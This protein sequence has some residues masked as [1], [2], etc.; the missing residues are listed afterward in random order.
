MESQRKGLAR[1][2]NLF[3]PAWV[4]VAC[5]LPASSH[6]QGA[7]RGAAIDPVKR[8]EQQWALLIGVNQYER[9]GSLRYCQRDM[10]SLKNRLIRSGFLAQNVRLLTGQEKDSL[11][12]PNK[13]NIDRELGRVVKKVGP[14]DLIVV[15]FSG[16]GACL[17]GT[18]YLC[19]ADAM[20]NKAEDT[21]ITVKSVYE[22]L[23]QCKAGYKLLIVDA[24]RNDPRKPRARSVERDDSLHQ[25]DFAGSMKD[26]PTGILALVSCSAGET[27]LEDDSLQHGVFMHF[28]IDGLAGNARDRDG[29]IRLLGLCNYATSKTEE[30]VGR[31]QRPIVRGD[32]PNCELVPAASM[33][34]A[35]FTLRSRGPNGPPAAN[36][37]VVLCRGDEKTKRWEE[38]ARGTTD[39]RGS[40]ELA[41]IAADLR[42]AG[43]EYRLHAKCK[44]NPSW[45]LPGFPRTP[46]EPLIILG[47][48]REWEET[49]ANVKDGELPIGWSSPGEGL[50]VEHK[51]G[52]ARLVATQEG[53][54]H[55]LLPAADISGDFMLEADVVVPAGGSH[56][57]STAPAFRIDFE[58]PGRPTIQTGVFI[59]RGAFYATLSGAPDAQ[60]KRPFP[61]YMADVA[62]VKVLRENGL[63]KVFVGGELFQSRKIDRPF[64][65]VRLVLEKASELH[66][67]KMCIVGSPDNGGDQRGG[68]ESRPGSLVEFFT[69]VPDGELPAGWQPE[70]PDAYR[71]QRVGGYPQLKMAQDNPQQVMLPV[72]DLPGDFNLECEIAVPTGYAKINAFQVELLSRTQTALAAGACIDGGGF[73]VTMTRNVKVSKSPWTRYMPDTASFRIT[74]ENGTIGVYVKDELFQ[75]IRLT[76]PITGVRLG[77]NKGAT[78]YSIK[79]EPVTS[80]APR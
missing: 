34:K 71:V 18:S 59:A 24:C 4:L 54:P 29:G 43:G 50:R 40:V 33:L 62:K 32:T 68:E 48:Q 49:F 13:K 25:N 26:P 2:T 42:E 23:S 30:Y 80:T 5:L 27:S 69:A 31:S 8:A 22:P 55:A 14:S 57:H 72:V 41:V 38:M 12:Y 65:R 56:S 9:L 74:R 44:G 36:T 58:A 51:E 17:E 64:S 75:S 19:P 53:R 77:L 37:E 39:Q 78:L 70:T 45:R 20:L 6:G 7:S 35:Q 79:V 11:D 3:V 63:F 47:D 76:Q 60:G 52:R 67:I 15:A 61:N 21:M 1:S 10:E 46:S 66:R 73:V 28:V 16:H